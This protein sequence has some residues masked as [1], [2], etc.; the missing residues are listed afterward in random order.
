MKIY[1]ITFLAILD[2]GCFSWR[3]AQIPVA[4]ALPANTGPL[5]SRNRDRLRTSEIVKAYPI[6]RYVDPASGRVMHEKH[7]IYRVEEDAAWNTWNEAK[8][9]NRAGNGPDSEVSAK[10]H[11]I[12]KAHLAAM[13]EQNAVLEKKIR[14]LEK[15]HARCLDEQGGNERR[16][17]TTDIV[18]S[19]RR[20]ASEIHRVP[21][22]IEPLVSKDSTS[23]PAP[24]Q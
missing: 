14:T 2:I 19:T 4:R 3:T 21:F 24:V 11:E 9:E 20:R 16:I 22:R 8:G 18:L 23:P 1:F 6:G 15:E 13:A 17:D 7:T 12:S 5:A 10:A